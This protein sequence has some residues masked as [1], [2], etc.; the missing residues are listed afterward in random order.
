MTERTALIRRIIEERDAPQ[1]LVESVFESILS[2]A[3]NPLQ[4]AAILGALSA[5]GE[6]AQDI[7][8][9]ALALRRRAITIQ[10]PE[11]AIDCCGTGGDGAKTYNIST[12]VA[13]VLAGA[14]VPVAK[15]GNRAASSASG[16]ADVLEALGCSF[17]LPMHVLEKALKDIGF[18]FLMAPRHH[19]AMKQV[20]SVRKELGVRTIFNLLG[21]LA[22]PA[23]AKRQLIGVYDERFLTPVAESLARLGSE[24]AWVVHGTDG[25]DEITLADQTRVAILKN[26]K[27]VEK[28]LYPSDFGFSF[29]AMQDIRGGDAVTNAQALQS[30]LEAAPGGY[31]DVVLANAAAG[32][33]LTE[34][35]KDLREGVEQAAHAI[36]SGAARRILDQYKALSS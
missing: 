5:R 8:G 32:L 25:L 10:A 15:H 4:I 27:V 12:A 11:G 24:A 28:T 16:A 6:T 26:G 1:D 21:P 13:F 17:D 14:G 30:L 9:A 22:N 7:T 20:S 34:R 23:G 2:G 31:R 19:E 18:C 35:A 3:M 36:D 33:V 29:V